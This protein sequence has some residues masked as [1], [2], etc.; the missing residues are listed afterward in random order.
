MKTI[1]TQVGDCYTCK[2]SSKRANMCASPSMCRTCKLNKPIN[3]QFHHCI[4]IQ[5]TELDYCEY[6]EKDTNEENR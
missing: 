1:R 4:C 2:Y 6:Y 3:G 5:E